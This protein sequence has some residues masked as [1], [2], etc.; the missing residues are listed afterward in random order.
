MNQMSWTNAF[1]RTVAAAVAFFRIDNNLT[2]FELHSA[3]LADFDTVTD[4]TAAAF[5]LAAL[6][7]C[8]N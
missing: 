6:G 2:V 1:S 4:T 7:A 3:L 5:A 8:F